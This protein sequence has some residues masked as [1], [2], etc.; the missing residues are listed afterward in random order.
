MSLKSKII[1]TTELPPLVARERLLAILAQ[2]K[3]NVYNS[4]DHE[5]VF[6]SGY[7]LQMKW[8]HEPDWH[9]L[10]EGRFS[11]YIEGGLTRVHLKYSNCSSTLIILVLVSMLIGIFRDSNVLI[12]AG[13]C[14]LACLY[15][16]FTHKVEA[17]TLIAACK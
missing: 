5:I 12:F 10:K 6:A 3:Y 11:I 8:R 15:E 7:L 17:K 13:L 1:D 2:K 4:L 9:R 14:I 16:C